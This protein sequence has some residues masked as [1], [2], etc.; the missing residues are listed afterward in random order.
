M[1]DNRLK[2]ECTRIYSVVNNVTKQVLTNAKIGDNLWK[3]HIP[4]ISPV[5]T[6]VNSGIFK[7]IGEPDIYTCDEEYNN[8]AGQ[9]I[10]EGIF[11]LYVS[12]EEALQVPSKRYAVEEG[13]F[14]VY[15][16]KRRVVDGE[17]VWE[18]FCYSI[19]DNFYI[20]IDEDVKFDDG[21]EKINKWR[22]RLIVKME[23]GSKEYPFD[24]DGRLFATSQDM[25]KVLI[26]IASTQV[27]FDNSKL[28]DIRNAAVLTS[29][30]IVREVSQ[31]FG[32][33]NKNV[34]Q[35][36]SAMIIK[37]GVK[38][39]EDGN[40]DLSGIGIAKNL[41]I[42]AIT[43]DEFKTVGKS[44]IKDLM[45]SHERYPIDCLFGFTFLAP[46]AS[47]IISAKKWSGG[48]IGLW[49]TGGSGCGK[50]YTSL[51][52]QNFFG[53]FYGENATFSWLGTPYSIQEGGYYFKDAIYMVDDFKIA[54]FSASALG[55]A[56]MVLQNYADGTARTR[57]GADMTVKEGKPIRGSILI[58]GEDVI[59]DVGSVMARYHIVEMNSDYMNENAIE[60]AYE[61]RELYNGFMGRYIAWL[62]KDPKYVDKIVG[63]IEK[64][65]SEFMGGKRSA[66]IHRV[67]Q[68][69]AYNLVGFE[70]FCRFLEESGFISMEK[71]VE[72]VKIHKN[73]LFSKIDA[74]VMEVRDATV[75]EIFINTL[76]DL[77][78]SGAVKIYH[79]GIDIGDPS[80]LKDEYIGFDDDRDENDKSYV[81]FFGIPV[82]NAVNRSA[83][84][85]KGLMNSK[86]N[87][88]NEL[89]KRNIMVPG[90]ETNT[91]RKKLN[92]KT[93]VTWRI[94][95]SALGYDYDD[96]FDRT[97][98]GFD[99]DIDGDDW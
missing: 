8:L 48:R 72:M 68:S 5:F 53:D 95:K 25:A 52:F 14:V 99:E 92:G 73:N 74:H 46:I 29:D 37:G 91:Y 76:K 71:Q 40:I 1:S 65:K 38:E 75:S 66:N 13:R 61:H 58:T 36:Q 94:L 20:V 84:S 35:S 97:S 69:F 56:V 44:I 67:A 28:K 96:A 98:S 6:E 33:H 27:P 62:L 39:M 51:L 93:Q 24:V 89:V 49:I 30:I 57:L 4:E 21:I 15:D 47:R 54:H 82:W 26:E 16:N 81:Y 32:W 50:S 64:W 34:Y 31:V 77:I 7:K 3:F 87:L 86:T 55:S 11:R 88:M 17:P 79:A 23:N 9:Y 78:N 70:M 10:S 22:G 63:K 19:T 2:I 80:D 12:D 60:A 85:G 41:D 42:K 59:D 43:N 90:N 45:H 83:G 18:E